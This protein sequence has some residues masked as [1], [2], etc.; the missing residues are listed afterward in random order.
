MRGPVNAEGSSTGGGPKSSS[1]VGWAIDAETLI[2]EK[3]IAPMRKQ[4]TFPVDPD[5][6]SCSPG[7]LATLIPK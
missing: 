1:A 3:R 4:Q 7:E 6:A 5:I 2:K